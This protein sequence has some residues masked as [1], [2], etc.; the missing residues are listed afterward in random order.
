MAKDVKPTSA[1]KGKAKAV[2]EKLPNGDSK[3]D[4]SKSGPDSKLTNGKKGDEPHEGTFLGC[5]QPTQVHMYM[6]GCIPAQR[7]SCV[8]VDIR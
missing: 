8:L 7:L 5:Q 6:E 4:G 2:D 3:T 1:E